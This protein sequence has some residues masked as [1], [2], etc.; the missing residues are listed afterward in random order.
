MIL[1][2]ETDKR[3][4]IAESKIPKAGKGVFA[5]EPLKAGDYLEIIG[6]YVQRD[7]VV[8]TCTNYARSY[9][10]GAKPGLDFTR[11]VMP[12][13]YAAIINHAPNE[14]VQNCRIDAHKGSKRNPNAG[15]LVYRF[16]RDIAVDEEVLGN[17]GEEWQGLLDWCEKQSSEA[18]QDEWET[19]VSFGLYNLG[20]LRQTL[21]E[22]CQS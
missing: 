18:E 19:F 7:S 4:Y 5:K 12:M 22:T 14:S 11:Y 6:V 16:I 13:G 9:K 20:I 17:Y 21:G 1:I 2:E 10:F 8:D 3:F 15:T